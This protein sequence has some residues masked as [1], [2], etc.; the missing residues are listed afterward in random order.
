M[1]T[2][3]TEDIN[4]TIR[5]IWSDHY[6][7]LKEKD[8]AFYY[9]EK[10]KKD[11]PKRPLATIFPFQYPRELK[12]DSLL[13]VGLCPSYPEKHLKD[14]G[15]D[16]GG[17]YYNDAIEALTLNQ[18]DLD[19]EKWR[20]VSKLEEYLRGVDEAGVLISVENRQVEA[21]P[22]QKAVEHFWDDLKD[23]CKRMPV[24]A[25]AG[26]PS[27]LPP[28]TFEFI[29]LF[30]L[31]ETNQKILIPYLEIKDVEVYAHIESNF[32]KDQ[33]KKVFLPLLNG[34]NPRVV[35]VINALASRIIRTHMKVEL[36]KDLDRDYG[37][38]F[39]EVEGN[40]VP[41]FFS[42]MLSGQHAL[43]KG[44]RERLLWQISKVLTMDMPCLNP[45]LR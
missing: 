8:D 25:N 34:L 7:F 31:R 14:I 10:A 13:L 27:H 36:S 29:D 17:N 21:H 3:D 38:H 18:G 37:C 39:V 41:I 9:T 6:D 16:I 2:I 40:Q 19:S 20:L 43:D 23:L 12:E 26:K 32:G 42:G 35:V 33:F 11:K 22:Y 28:L 1:D 15:K 45:T 44:S 30:A 5:E 24:D 4:G